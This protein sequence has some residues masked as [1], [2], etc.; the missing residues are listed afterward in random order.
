MSH[1]ATLEH[2][3]PDQPSGSRSAASL[4]VHLSV[5]PTS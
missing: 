4:I 1:V 3:D 2:S 5:T